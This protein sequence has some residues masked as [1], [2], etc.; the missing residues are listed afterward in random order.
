MTLV[1]TCMAPDF[2]IQVSDKRIRRAGILIDDGYSIGFRGIGLGS[3]ELGF[4]LSL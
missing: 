1:L 3:R 4:R 2:G